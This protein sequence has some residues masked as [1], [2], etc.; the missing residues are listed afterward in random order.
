[1]SKE[2]TPANQEI[3]PEAHEALKTEREAA[4]AAITTAVEQAT[5]PLTDRIV[6][7]ESEVGSKN[8]DI[9]VLKT[10]L[11][12]SDKSFTSLTASLDGAVTA[13]KGALLKANPLVPPELISGATISEVDTSVEKAATIVG[14][15]KKGLA[16]EAQQTIIPNGAPGRTP[17]DTS[18]MSTREKINHGLN[19]RKVNK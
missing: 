17:P 12:D 13:Y 1:L 10:K 2:N 5:R 4:K 8:Q 3:T 9:D 18:A 15:I 6:T 19:S 14:K 7:L 16:S 11:S